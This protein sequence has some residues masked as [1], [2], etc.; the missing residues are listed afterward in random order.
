MATAIDTRYT[1]LEL[2]IC[3]H[4]FT[5]GGIRKNNTVLVPVIIVCSF[6]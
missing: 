2:T 5:N 1:H 3:Y 6:L 4:K